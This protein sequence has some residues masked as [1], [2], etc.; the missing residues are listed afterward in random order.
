MAQRAPVQEERRQQILGAAARVFAR[1]GFHATRV[2][3]IAKE[4]GVAYGL[5]YHYFQ[6]KDEVLETIFRVTWTHMLARIHEVEQSGEPAREQIRRVAALVLR[7]WIRDPDVV[8]VLVHEIARS[9]HIQEEVDEIRLAFDA[10]ERIV[11]DGQARG[12]LRDDVDA[13]VAAY[14][15]YG[16]LEEILTGWVMGG[17]P[18]KDE[19]VARAERAVSAVLT[20]GLL[21]D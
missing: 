1:R 12:E 7:S 18:G 11:R 14:I 19:D 17:L 5:V 8:R 6:S 3:D 21:T 9:P 13:R 20:R 16:S 4:A 10:L 15:F 2:G